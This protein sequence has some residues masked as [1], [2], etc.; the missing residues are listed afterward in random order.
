MNFYNSINTI[1]IFNFWK[2]QTTDELKY[3]FKNWSEIDKAEN[4]I[5][6]KKAR[7]KI[8]EE[9]DDID[10]SLPN[11]YVN[12]QKL[13]SRFLAEKTNDG[14]NVEK[15]RTKF[16]F[17]FAKYLD[18]LNIGNENFEL[19]NLKNNDVREL[20]KLIKIEKR[21][22]KEDYFFEQLY[23]FNFLIL[24]Y[25]SKNTWDLYSEIYFISKYMKISIDA[26]TMP[27]AQYLSFKKNAI[28]EIEKN[29]KKNK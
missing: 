11:S 20:H 17:A 25:K 2:L 18:L 19:N 10:F 16:Y 26:N 28:K 27:T 3:I 7:N 24:K 4:I 15:H 1:P 23:D 5:D 22:N 6:I 29:N 12:C 13:M 9:V 8:L 21:N 14:K